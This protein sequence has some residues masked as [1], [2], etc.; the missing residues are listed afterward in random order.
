MSK[1]EPLIP[2]D[3]KQCQVVISTYKPFILGG[4]PKKVERCTNMPTVIARE[5][6]KGK[7]GRKGAMS[8]CDSCKKVLLEENPNMKL[9]EI[10]IQPCVVKSHFDCDGTGQMCGTCGESESA[11]MCDESDLENCEGCEGATRICVEHDSPC[12]DLS[13]NP[14]CDAV[15]KAKKK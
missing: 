11:C 1:K 3:L 4:R 8:L 9:E 12:G 2:P 10:P 13:K 15:K 14:K 5:T 7:D 6:K